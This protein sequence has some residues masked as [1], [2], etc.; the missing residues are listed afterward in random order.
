MATGWRNIG[1]AQYYFSASGA[2]TTGFTRIGSYWY[3]FDASGV[4]L[5]GWQQ[6]GG[7]DRYFYPASGAMAVNTVIDGYPIG[8]DGV[9]QDPA[10]TPSPDPT[11]AP[12]STLTANVGSLVIPNHQ[13]QAI[14]VTF[15]A[16]GTLNCKVTNPSVLSFRWANTWS[17]NSVVLYVYP[18]AVGTASIVITNTANT[19]TLIIPV[20]VY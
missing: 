20:T 2:M 19:D 7:K 13:M 1:G 11:P 10:P 12:V 6:I 5:T 17:G 14:V 3:V 15:T 4:M 16:K 18:G 8:P 9:R